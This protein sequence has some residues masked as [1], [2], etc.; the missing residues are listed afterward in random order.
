[1]ERRKRRRRRERRKRN[2]R[3]GGRAD[4]MH[5]C[6]KHSHGRREIN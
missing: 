3:E 6:H 5:N 2:R 1:L 4:A